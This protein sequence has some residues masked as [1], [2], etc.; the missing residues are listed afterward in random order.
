[1]KSFCLLLILLLTACSTAPVE[2]AALPT[3]VEIAGEAPGAETSSSR[4]T[5]PPS[6]T[7]TFT[8]TVTPSP[9]ETPTPSVTPSATITET[10]RPTLTFSPAPPTQERPITNL[11][12]LALRTTIL[13]PDFSLPNYPGPNITLAPPGTSTPGA[14]INP[15]DT[16][17]CTYYPSGGF[18]SVFANDINIAQRLGCPT[19]FPPTTAL[20]NG[21]RQSFERGQM[22]WLEGPPNQIYALFENGTFQSFAD[23]YQPDVDPVSGG[24]TPPAGLIEPVRGFGK[25]WRTFNAVKGSLGWAS[26]SEIS[27]QTT[28]QSFERGVMLWGAGEAQILVLMTNSDGVTG[29]WR[30]VPGQF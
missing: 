8:A 1:M 13:P 26:A 22:I 7:P 9:S 5:L 14:L 11:I 25:I 28:T 24:E 12:E 23:L 10:P 18:A 19:G 21:V 6:W 27:V 17:T 15:V 16:V 3:L 2:Q 30:A 4:P 20:V 29:V